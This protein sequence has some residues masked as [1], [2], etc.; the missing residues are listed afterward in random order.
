MHLR[1]TGSLTLIHTCGTTSAVMYS[2]APFHAN[3]YPGY[4]IS[5][6]GYIA[7]PNLLHGRVR[8][9]STASS[10][11][12]PS[13]EWTWCDISTMRVIYLLDIM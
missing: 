12:F 9:I 5:Y 11:S 10:S 2:G 8:N 1:L 13:N 6:S 4:S 3:K 7:L